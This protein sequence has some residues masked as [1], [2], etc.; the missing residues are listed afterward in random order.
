[1]P[2]DVTLPPL[3]SPIDELWHVLLDLG[4][5]LHV[6]WT[7]VGG[8]MVLLHALEQGQVPPQVSQD[9]DV[10]ADIRTDPGGIRQVVEA[11]EAM[12][13]SLEN[14]SGED[15][16]HRYVRTS[17]RAGE[18]KIDI[19]APEGLGSRADL[20]TT[21]PGRTVQM[22]G[23]SQALART[24]RV[25]V[26]HEGRAESVPRPS[27]LGAI[28]AKAA[29][30]GLPGESARHLRDLALLSA[31]VPDPFALK[32]ELVAKDRQRLRQASALD[33]PDHP[34][35]LLVPESI[36]ANGRVAFD[37]LRDTAA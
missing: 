10:V 2:A 25:Q 20:T 19:L 33:A 26:R 16:A 15:L 13:F 4:R 14:F 11:L 29:A 21:R 23:G 17:G 18:V 31:V 6:P 22:P 30:C 24:E 1:M 9:G 7:I 32:A 35:W 12:D 28:V 27:L 37:I 8:Q 5:V 34:A 3:P 36:R